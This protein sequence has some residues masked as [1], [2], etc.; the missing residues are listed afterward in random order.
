MATMKTIAL[1]AADTELAQSLEQLLEGLPEETRFQHAQEDL[2]EIQRNQPD[3][4]ILGSAH[5]ETAIETVQQ[6]LTLN[7][8]TVIFYVSERSDFYGMRE[9]MRVGAAD[10]FV[11]P[12]EYP[13]LESA[14]EKTVRLLNQQE[15]AAVPSFKKGRGKV[16]AFY[17]GKGGSGT[18]LLAAS[19]A[20]TL[21][22]ES[23]ARVLLIDLNMQYGGAEYYLGL[24]SVRSLA[25]L[26]PVIEEV[27][28]GHLRNVAQ[29][30]KYSGLEVLLSPR[31]AEMA[32]QLN[33]EF[34]AKLLRASRL[35]YDYI[36]LDLPSN[37]NA[38]NLAALE[39]ADRI[40]YVMNLDTPSLRTYKSV[41]SLFLRLNLHLED[42]LEI[43]INKKSREN[44]ITIQDIKSLVEQPISVELIR[45]ERNVQKAVNMGEPLRKEVNEKKLVPLAREIRKWVAAVIE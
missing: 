26:Q 15:Q 37:M 10:Y 45:D 12:D 18:T 32:E 6:F 3:I 40:Y 9:M 20:Q 44:E 22:L 42:R 39:E 41:E 24:E 33:D 28:E 5:H 27:N 35:S 4:L 14:L 31:D 2:R 25:D 13:L 43:L 1:L 38:I 34:V 30:E 8:S 21:R 16:L 7:P 23:T 19:F 36:I 17:S 11:L 29:T